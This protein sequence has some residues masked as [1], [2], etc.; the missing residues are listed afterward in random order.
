MHMTF[1]ISYEFLAPLLVTALPQQSRHHLF[2][3]PRKVAQVS[4]LH[5][6]IHHVEDDLLFFLHNAMFCRIPEEGGTDGV[7][8][9]HLLGK[10]MLERRTRMV[11]GAFLTQVL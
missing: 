1:S 4:A 6:Q 2:M 10:L 11:S 3:P 8:R 7:G 9:C 5:F